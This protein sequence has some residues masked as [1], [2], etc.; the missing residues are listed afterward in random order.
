MGSVASRAS[1]ILCC[2][3]AEQK[4]RVCHRDNG[5][6][7]PVC[8]ASTSGLQ[9]VTDLAFEARM[10]AK[11]EKKQQAPSSDQDATGSEEE[12]SVNEAG[13]QCIADVGIVLD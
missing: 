3:V 2:H 13:T 8:G 9:P 6:G 5:E 10:C 12:S 11:C 7:A 4:K 1:A